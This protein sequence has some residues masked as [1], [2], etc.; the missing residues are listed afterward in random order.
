MRVGHELARLADTV[1]SNEDGAVVAVGALSLSQTHTV[2]SGQCKRN[3]CICVCVCVC[4]HLTAL[5]A[6]FFWSFSISYLYLLQSHNRHRGG[7]ASE[8]RSNKSTPE[9]CR[10]TRRTCKKGQQGKKAHTASA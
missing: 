4:T 5:A 8:L 9:L 2:L 7:V 10:A 6:F 1:Q 3:L